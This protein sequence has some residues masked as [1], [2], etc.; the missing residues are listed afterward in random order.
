MISL[1]HPRVALLLAIFSIEAN[2]RDAGWNSLGMAIR[3]AQDIGLYTEAEGDA[4]NNERE[5]RRRLWY[6]IYACDT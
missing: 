5:P 3:M 4:S 1:D 2:Q 6:C